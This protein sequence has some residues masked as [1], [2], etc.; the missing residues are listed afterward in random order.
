MDKEVDPDLDEI[1]IA[2]G[3]LNP[4]P[5]P[6][7][8]DVR[9]NLD[10]SSF[11]FT[12]SESQNSYSNDP[13]RPIEMALQHLNDQTEPHSPLSPDSHQNLVEILSPPAS[14]DTQPPNS[15]S[16]DP[17][18]PIEIALQHLNDQTEPHSPLSPDSH[19][20]LVEILSPPASP[21]TQPPNSYSNDPLR[22][23]EMALQHLNDQTEPHSPLSPDSHQDLIEIFSLPTSSSEESQRP[24]AHQRGHGVGDDETRS[25]SHDRFNTVVMRRAFTVPEPAAEPNLAQF[26]SDVMGII[27]RL[28]LEAELH[29]RRNDIIQLEVVGENV[30]DHVSVVVADQGG[31]VLPAFEGLLDRLVQSNNSIVADENVEFVVQVV[32]NPRGGGKRKLARTLDCEIV[33]KK[34]RCLYIVL[35]RKD[36]LCFAISLAHVMHPDHTV[37]QCVKLARELQRQAGLDEQTPVTFGDVSRFEEIVKRKIVIFYP[38]SHSQPLSHFETDY[39]DRSRPLFLFLL[40]NHYYGIKNLKAFIGAKFVCHH[41]Y[42]GFDCSYVHS[43]RGYCQVCNDPICPTEDLQP[44]HCSDCNRICRS[45]SCFARHKETKPSHLN[46][47]P[48]A[49]CDRVKKCTRCKLCYY[50][51]MHTGKATHSCS[52]KCKICGEKLP[53]GSDVILGNHQCYIQPLSQ[54]NDHPDLVFYDFETFVNEK[55]EHIPFL[56]CAK[57][58]KGTEKVFYGLQCVK[59]FLLHFR[60]N[61]YRRNVFIAHNARGFDGYLILRGMLKEGVVPQQILMTGSKLLSFEEP[62]YQLKFIDSLSFLAMR[63]SAMPKALGFTDQIKGYFPHHF[64]SAGRLGYVGVYPLPAEYGTERMTLT[65]QKEFYEWYGQVS[66]GT[67]DFRKEAVRYCKNDVDILSKACVRF[68][69]QFLS[70]TGVDPFGSITI[71]SACMRVFLT[72]FLQPNT[73]AIPCPYEYRGQCKRFSEPSIQWLEWVMHKQKIFIQHALNLGEKQIGSFFVDGYAEIDGV[74]CV[75]E[76]HGCFYHGCPSCFSPTETCTLRGVSFGELHVAGEDRVRRLESQHGIRV[77]VMRE[78]VWNEM[79][80][81]CAEVK[82]FLSV[83]DPPEPLSP[84]KALYGGRTCALKLRHTAEPEEQ[85]HYVDFTS[86]YPFVNSTCSYP[87]GHPTIIYKDFGD[88][89]DYYGFIRATVYPPRGLF[90]PVLPYKTSQGK[91]IFTLCRTCA[92]NNHQEGPCHHDDEARA[93]TGVWVSVEFHKALE[94]GYRVGKITE[95]WHFPDSSDRVFVDY[96]HTFLKGKQEASGYPPEASDEVSREEYIRDY[97]VHQNIQLDP[98]KIE[99]NPVKRQVAKLCLNSLWGKFAQRHN[100]LQTCIVT[101]P[102][103]F[104]NYLFSGKYKVEYFQ[105]LDS[106]RALLQWK[107]TE[108]CIQPPGRQSNVFL[109]AFTTA[110]ARLKLYSYLEKLQERVL[111]TDTD[112]LIYVVKKGET[113]L[114][115][116]N[117]LGDLTD[118]L[119]GD[120]IQEFVAAGPKSYAYQTKNKKKMVMRVKGITQTRECCER[121][122]FDSV[123]E[124]VEGFQ[125]HNSQQRVIN[126]P[127]HNIVRNKSGFVLKNLTFQKKFRVVYDKRRLL[128]DGTS[129]PFGY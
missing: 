66:R 90:F 15:Y 124:L 43:C 44:L 65:E 69:E 30:R 68:R 31:N 86:L 8:I 121:V 129:L 12:K 125:T 58:L 13:L 9:H 57:T 25:T 128:A 89:R 84:R 20:N 41:C 42:K 92:E 105:V 95:V 10:D 108:R 29:A 114:V 103:E 18:R 35:N 4:T 79:K 75:W 102:E 49:L 5:V 110:H 111:Y 76:F 101:E 52:T 17:L 3:Q 106:E 33:T 59:H 14:P 22:P 40:Q 28:S 99:K 6:S 78:H 54:I 56:V 45:I 63:L 100:L 32:R 116:G 47:Q 81:S 98:T 91:L 27:H 70:E 19:Q 11:A 1:A 37:N 119:E 85:I 126:T 115:L 87:L 21:D 82:E 73:L 55:G 94:M 60:S 61:R 48:S 118:E 122:N 36:Q 83:F 53:A 23:I 120:S 77:V 127:Q 34:K 123:R 39:P 7:H 80:K 24:P 38:T 51:N 62:H 64:S 2:L 117:Y 97:Q 107:H 50:V 88:P 113:P 46:R 72:K 93:L 104:F 112:S 26:Y 74:K 16:N 67:F 71:A 109:A 96:I